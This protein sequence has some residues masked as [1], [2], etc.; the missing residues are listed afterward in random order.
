SGRGF[1]QLCEVAPSGVTI[2]EKAALP[3]VRAGL[4]KLEKLP[5]L[6]V[7]PL[8]MALAP[9]QCLAALLQ[10]HSSV[11]FDLAGFGHPQRWGWIKPELG[12][13]VWDPLDRRE[14]KS[15]RQLFGHYTF[16]IFRENG[17]DAL[18]SLDDNGDSMLAGVELDGLSVWFD[19]NSD[20]TSTRDEVTP[21]HDLGI[22]RLD[23]RAT[24]R[25]DRHPTNPRGVSFTDG[26][27]LPTWDWFPKQA[28]PL[29]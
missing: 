20:G 15:G 11:E 25:D 29:N 2:D 26:R 1:V 5:Q 28:A 24:A 9:V 12:L 6:V 18:A 14:I 4:E 3:K 13:L 7:T 27:E 23:C 8:V 16:R 21:V 22:D 17:Y 10:P 19:R